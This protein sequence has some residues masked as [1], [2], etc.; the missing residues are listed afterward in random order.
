MNEVVHLAVRIKF[1]NMEMVFKNDVGR[2]SGPVPALGQADDATRRSP[3]VKAVS[4]VVPSVV[5]ISTKTRVQRVG[6][7]YDWWRDN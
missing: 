5:N 2:F 1:L 4:Q 7:L 3:T 6:Y